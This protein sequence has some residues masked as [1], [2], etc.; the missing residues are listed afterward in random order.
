MS[1]TNFSNQ[2]IGW[3]PQA[4]ADAV[5]TLSS[6]TAS[7][8]SRL[9]LGESSISAAS[10][11]TSLDTRVSTEIST[12]GSADTSLTTRVSTSDSSLT[13]LTTRVSTVE[14]TSV[15]A[16]VS[17]TT[18]VS[19]AESTTASGDTSL[20]T[21]VSTEGSTR[22][23]ADTSLTTR[24]STAESTETSSAASLDTRVSTEISTR[25]SADT[26][27]TTRV[28]TE[29]STRASADT[30]L[31]T[32]V[33]TEESARTSAALSLDGRVDVF[34][35]GSVCFSVYDFREVDASGDVGNIA[36]NGG[37]LASDTTPSLRANAAETQE[38]SWATGNTDL[39]ATTRML[40][41]DFS[42]ASNV[43][44]SISVYSGTTNAAT[45]TVETGW[46]GGALVSDTATDGSPS[47][48]IH[49]ITATIAAADIPDT[50]SILTIILTPAAHAT[51]TIQLLGAR[52]NYVSTAGA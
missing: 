25:G 51:D 48:S 47:A 32:R 4:T 27:L 17:L 35:A 41:A 52:L 39:V 38:I 46:D 22:A 21:S 42:G 10:A 12:R 7:I 33:S 8:E 13:S 19:T 37:L 16:D 2:T 30:S 24:V 31:T 14:S 44:L 28:S 36:A 26:S 1:V 43:T 23:S 50:A 3:N 5:S 18:R 34:A 9:S 15:S 45:F 11:I 49:T 29:E 6:E 40:P 20:T